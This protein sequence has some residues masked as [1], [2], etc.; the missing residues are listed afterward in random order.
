MLLADE[1]PAAL[2]ELAAVLRDLGH[3][4]IARAVSVPAAAGAIGEEDPDAALVVLHHD[5]EHALDL[6]EEI[7]EYASG[8]VIALLD[9]EDPDYVARAAERG[10]A[11]YARLPEPGAVRSALEIAPAPPCRDR[12]A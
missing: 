8:P 6:I 12:G 7:A 2:D 3:E 9:D 5:R 11:A 1:D 4:V 10:V